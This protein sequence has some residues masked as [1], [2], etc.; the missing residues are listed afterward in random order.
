MTVKEN[1]PFAKAELYNF[2]A[3]K[4]DDNT[5]IPVNDFDRTTYHYGTTLEPAAVSNHT[6]AANGVVPVAVPVALEESP[7]GS[8]AAAGLE[9]NGIISTPTIP[10]IPSN[11]NNNWLNA[12]TTRI[13]LA[14]MKKKRKQKTICAGVIGGVAGMLIISPLFG[15]IVGTVSALVVKKSLKKKERRKLKKYHA[16]AGNHHTATAVEVNSR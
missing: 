12:P 1:I 3:A 16:R 8:F 2:E 9:N 4:A 5:K 13:D 7:N 14:K 6:S 15:I 10:C 11:N